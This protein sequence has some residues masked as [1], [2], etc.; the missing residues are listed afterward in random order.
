MSDRPVLL[1]NA[2]DIL[3]PAMGKHL[4]PAVVG[5]AVYYIAE[6]LG[7][8]CISHPLYHQIF[9]HPEIMNEHL[10]QAI[11]LKRG[12]IRDRA[13]EGDWGGIECLYERPYRPEF[14]FVLEAWL[15]GDSDSARLPGFDY[16]DPVHEIAYDRW[17]ADTAADDKL[18][19][20]LARSTWVDSENIH[21]HVDEWMNLFETSK[22]TQWMRG[23]DEEVL[24]L[25]PKEVTIFRGECNDG[26]VSWSLDRDIGE[27]FARRGINESTGEVRVAKIP[28]HMIHSFFGERGE[29]E[30][31][32]LEDDLS[33]FEIE[34]YSV[35][36]A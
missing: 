26:R 35:K 24:K 12:L 7:M 27:F 10:D 23:F 6:G 9:F 2:P 33:D 11:R 3:R 4:D 28:K 36:A 14:I 21:Q 19:Y 18:F 5:D 16:D 29:E 31:I 8:P 25:I 17:Q 20:L 30:V 15:F 22:G 13:K 32:I 1:R 34:R